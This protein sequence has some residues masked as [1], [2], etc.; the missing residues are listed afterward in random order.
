MTAP[1]DVAWLGF[2]P[3]NITVAG[4]EEAAITGT[5]AVCEY[6]GSE[7]YAFID[8]G[9]E[10]FVTGRVD[11]DLELESGAVVGINFDPHRIHLFDTSGDRL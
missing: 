5:V 10:T 11:P 9:F 3:E 8:C 6:L 4:V 2:R 1:M 7:Q